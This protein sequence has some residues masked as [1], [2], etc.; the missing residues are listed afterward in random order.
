MDGLR[1]PCLCIYLYTHFNQSSDSKCTQN[2]SGIWICNTKPTHART[3][4]F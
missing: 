2:S 1:F 4:A 3:Y